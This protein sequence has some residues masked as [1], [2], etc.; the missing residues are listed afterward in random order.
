[1]KS[2]S[3]DMP[4]NGGARQ[5]YNGSRCI[6]SNADTNKVCWLEVKSILVPWQDNHSPYLVHP[7]LETITEVKIRVPEV[8]FTVASDSGVDIKTS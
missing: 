4:G 8:W 7:V 1:M 3:G 6:W 5:T 2:A